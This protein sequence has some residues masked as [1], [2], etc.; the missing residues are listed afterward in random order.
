MKRCNR[1]YKEPGS[2]LLPLQPV[3]E[4]RNRYRTM[5]AERRRLEAFSKTTG[6]LVRGET[7]ATD[8]EVIV[9]G[10]NGFVVNG[11]LWGPASQKTITKVLF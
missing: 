4:A 10:Q 11:R 8:Q 6:S 3:T 5:Q 7:N 2:G 1:R 9:D